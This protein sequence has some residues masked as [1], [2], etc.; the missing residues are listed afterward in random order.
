MNYLIYI[1]HSAENLQF[2]LWYRDYV[3]RFNEAP[4][5]ET[6]LAP[7]WTR[8][9]E[10]NAATRI[11]K[12]ATGKIKQGI[13]TP[14][15]I[16]EGTD[17]EKTVEIHI[18]SRG[19]FPAPHHSSD[20]NR[21]V[22]S[23]WSASQAMTYEVVAQDAFSAAGAKQPCKNIFCYLVWFISIYSGLCSYYPTL[24]N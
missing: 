4:I 13:S 16:F 3:K 6:A 23:F 9:M 22:A 5:S 17:F 10:Y 18:E 20:T 19:P 8:A 21:D 24:S 15:G 11:H 12:D 7:E 2:F 14:Q 1:E